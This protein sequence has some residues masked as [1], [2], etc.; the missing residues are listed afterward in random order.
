MDD[1]AIT[2]NLFNYTTLYPQ[3]CLAEHHQ[4]QADVTFFLS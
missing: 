1:N 2:T 4:T 3:K